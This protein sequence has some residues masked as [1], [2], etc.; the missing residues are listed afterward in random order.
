MVALISMILM[1]AVFWG[2][3]LLSQWVLIAGAAWYGW[4]FYVNLRN[5]VFVWG[6]ILRRR[7]WRESYY[8][9]AYYQGDSR[10]VANSRS[11]WAPLRDPLL[12]ALGLVVALGMISIYRHPET[13]PFNHH[14]TAAK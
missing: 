10:R 9:S 5:T 14:S 13:N 11:T 7:P 6:S 8:R 12:M 3:G 1:Q 2:L 4:I